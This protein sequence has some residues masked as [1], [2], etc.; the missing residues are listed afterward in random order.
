INPARDGDRLARLLARSGVT[1]LDI[2]T[3][4][5]PMPPDETRWKLLSS[6]PANALPV[7]VRSGQNLGRL[8]R[9]GATARF[10]RFASLVDVARATRATGARTAAIAQ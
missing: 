4:A 2:A 3:T 1:F 7:Y 8:I 5:R 6:M 9:D 10:E